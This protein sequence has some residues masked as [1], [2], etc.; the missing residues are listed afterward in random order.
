[1]WF[2]CAESNESVKLTGHEADEW[3]VCLKDDKSLQRDV[4]RRFNLTRFNRKLKGWIAS[5]WFFGDFTK[6][7]REEV[8][9]TIRDYIANPN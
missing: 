9:T 5:S 8:E 6:Q 7:Q 1:M 2:E 4:Y 3:I